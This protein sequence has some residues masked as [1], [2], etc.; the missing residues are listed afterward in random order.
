MNFVLEFALH[1]FADSNC[2]LSILESQLFMIKFVLQGILNSIGAV[3]PGMLERKRGHIV[4]I[5][6]DAG[7]KVR[8]KMS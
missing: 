4:N 6:S 7:R 2:W 5:S 8:L 3:L 1:W